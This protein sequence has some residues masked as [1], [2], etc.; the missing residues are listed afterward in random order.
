MCALRFSR[1][2]WPQQPFGS[3]CDVGHLSSAGL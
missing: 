1:G 2:F 3:L